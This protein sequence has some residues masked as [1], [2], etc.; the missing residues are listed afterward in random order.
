MRIFQYISILLF[1][2][3]VVFIIYQNS[4]KYQIIKGK[5]Y[6]TYYNIKINTPNKNKELKKEINQVLQKIDNQMSV[7][8]EASEISQ[9]NKTK[10]NKTIL[11]SAELSEVLKVSHKIWKQSN[12]WF[13]PTL[14]NL[15][16]LWGFGNTKAKM[17][18]SSE[19]KKVLSYTGFDKLK[20]KNNYT[21]LSKTNKNISVNLS[22]IAKGY[23]VDKVAE[24]LDNKGYDNY[25]V[26][27]GGEV[28]TKGYRS[29][30]KDAWNV[31]I[32]KPLQD[33]DENIMVLSLSNIAVATSGNY[34]NYYK[35]DGEV[36][37]HTISP[38]NGYPAK[39]DILS[40]TV[41]H[42]SCMYA[43]AY[44]TAINAMGIKRGLKFAEKNNIKAIIYD[45]NMKA[46]YTK[47]AEEIME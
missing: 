42:D 45:S 12:G 6:G 39:T 15:I 37:A 38:E 47:N 46:V 8:N 33:S 35:K 13:D 28:K 4:P 19:I 17:P 3:A 31:A 24:M 23:A 40:V 7:F 1:S 14:G 16:N 29:Q 36:Y 20:F 26:D 21:K 44:A 32:N 41:F 11:L 10:A 22:A 25:I 2:F 34:R 18:T 27:I 9:I 30:N 5:I 43:D